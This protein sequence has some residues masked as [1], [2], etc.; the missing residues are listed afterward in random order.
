M[1]SEKDAGTV[2]V[3]TQDD[4]DALWFHLTDDHGLSLL[5]LHGDPFLMHWAATAHGLC[6]LTYV[7]TRPTPPG[8]TGETGGQR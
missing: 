6:R 8:S 2:R 4:M 7:D 1:M 3:S 5:S